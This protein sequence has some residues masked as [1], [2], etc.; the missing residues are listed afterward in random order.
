MV[1]KLSFP[2]VSELFHPRCEICRKF[3]YGKITTYLHSNF[4]FSKRPVY[5]NRRICRRCMDFC[6]VYQ[7]RDRVET[8]ISLGVVGGVLA[9][10]YGIA[11]V[12]RKENLKKGC[13][14][15]S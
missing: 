12:I 6:R 2:M 13:R 5:V 8:V 4:I 10:Y 11:A 7:E 14:V 15:K 1:L 9:I 3:R